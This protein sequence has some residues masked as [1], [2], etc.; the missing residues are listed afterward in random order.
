MIAS[1]HVVGLLLA[2]GAGRRNGSPK[3]LVDGWLRHSVEALLDGGCDPVIVILGAGAEAARD[4]VPS[5]VDVLIADDWDLGMGAS[6][7]AGLRAADATL[8]EAAMIHLV[9]LPDV[10]SEVIARLANVA[11][12]GALA[13]AVYGGVAGHPVVVGR[14]H[15][16]GLAASAVGDQGGRRY[17]EQRDVTQV[18]CGDLA[19]GRD[20]DHRR[21][22]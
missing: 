10:T 22:E 8:S 5:G 3:A 11:R 16:V 12:P 13:R 20:V 21:G 7:R 2:A 9:D 17:L 15:W 19:S 4:L 14:D 6:L 1:R 18:E